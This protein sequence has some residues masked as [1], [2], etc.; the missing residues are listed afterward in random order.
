MSCVNLLPHQADALK[1]TAGLNRVA[2]YH[3]M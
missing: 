3:D 1:R 2:F